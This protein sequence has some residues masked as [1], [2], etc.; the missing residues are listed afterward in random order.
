MFSGWLIST[1]SFQFKTLKQKCFS[2]FN[3]D[4]SGPA[5]SS[6][7]LFFT[8]KRARNVSDRRVTSDEV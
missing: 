6:G 2:E 7:A 1:L 4:S 3:I 8:Q 5:S